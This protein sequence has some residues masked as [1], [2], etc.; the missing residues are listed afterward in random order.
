MNLGSVFLLFSFIVVQLYVIT[1]RTEKRYRVDASHD[2]LTGVLNR[3]AVF[4]LAG[5]HCQRGAGFALLLLDA[6][7][8]KAVNDNHGHSAGDEVLRHLA[9]ILKKTLREGDLLGR[10]GGEEFLVILPGTGREEALMV[11]SR[12]RQG[13]AQ[14]PCRLQKLT[15]P[16]TLSMGLALSREA[17]QLSEMIDLADRRLYAAKSSGRDQLVAEGHEAGPWDGDKQDIKGRL[18]QGVSQY[19]CF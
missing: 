2:S 19:Q 10:V 17:T 14:Q 8:F 15:L 4:E 18:A 7:H 16:V 9:M 13:L 6:D 11:A 1:A 12:L 3:R 5:E